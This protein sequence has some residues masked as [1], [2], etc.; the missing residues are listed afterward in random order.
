MKKFVTI[1]F[2]LVATIAQG[3]Q[4][5]TLFAYNNV[6]QIAMSADEV[7]ALSDGSLFS[8]NKHSEQLQIYNNLHS[9]GISCIYYDDT[10]A[11]LF[12]GYKTGKIDIM[13]SKGVQYI[14]DLYDKDMVQ[15]K[16]IYNVTVHGQMAYLSTHY[17]IQT[18]D[19]GTHR[20]VDS[21]WL[22]P[23]GQETT[24]SDVL[25]A[26]D[27]IYAFTTDSMFC[28]ALRDNLVDYTY[29][30][31]EGR[32][33][34]ISPDTDKGVHY[35]DGDE[36]WYAG[37]ADGIVRITPTERLVYK[38]LGPLNN[39]P[40]RITTAGNR[41]YVVSGGR[42]A[43][44]YNKPGAVMIYEDGTWTNISQADIIAEVGSPVKDF[45]NV[46]VDPF[47]NEHFF[48]TSYGTGLYEFREGTAVNK[49]L[50]A[51]DNPLESAVPSAPQTYTR[52]DYATYD[53]EGN[54]WFING[55]G[56][57]NPIICLDAQKE[58]HALPLIVDNQYAMLNCPGG[59][60]LDKS[61]PNYK[62]ISTARSNTTLFLLDDNGTPF[63]ASDDKAIG[64]NEWLSPS[65]QRITIENIL[66]MIQTKDGRI[67]L[68]TDIG[69]IIIDTTD[70]FTDDRCLRPELMD[71]NGENPMVSQRV[72]ALC[73]DTSGR[74]W[75]GTESLG[76]YVLNDQAT[77]I[78]A[79]YT[80]DNT[81]M[82]SNAI[83]S[84]AC[85]E[86]GIFYVGSGEGLIS[87]D[88]NEP[89]QGI[90]DTEE[91]TELDPGSMKQWRLHNSYYAPEELATSP[92]YVFAVASGALYAVNRQTE[93]IE[94]WSK[95]TGLTGSSIQHIAYDAN[96]E[97]L[98]ITYENGRIDLLNKN[99]D[100]VPMPDLF[101]KANSVATTV[102]GITVGKK[103]TYLAMTFGVI[104]IHPGKAEVI[105]TYYIG[106]GATSVD[107]KQVVEMGDSIYAF[108][109]DRM[110]CA[111]L[112]DNLVDYAYWQSVALPTDGLTH[113][114]AFNG[115]LYVLLHNKL[116][117]LEGG[118]W[119]QV[120][121]NELEWIHVSGGQLLA[122][123]NNNGL[124]R[125]TDDDQ[126]SGITSNYT[127][128][129]AVYSQGEYWLAQENSGLVRISSAGVNYFYPAGPSTNFAY[130]LTAAHD[131]IYMVNGGR[132]ASQ[133]MRTAAINTFNG[134]DWKRTNW[135][136]IYLSTNA[137]A[138]DPVSIAVDPNDAG[139]YFVA[140][141]TAGVFEFRDYKPIK[142]HSATNSTLRAVTNDA[143]YRYYTR[144]DGATM[145]AE[146]NLWVMNATSIGH[147]LHVLT[148]D[149]QWHAIPLY[150]G[151]QSISFTTPSGIHIDYRNS[152]RKWMIEQRG[153]S[154]VILFDDGGTPTNTS[155]DHSIKRSTWIDQNSRA[156][157]PDF[158][159]CLSQDL[160]NRIWIGTSAGI[161]IIPSNV[162][163]LNSNACRRI[164]I[165]RNDGTGLGDYLLGDER[166]N[167]MAVDGGNRMWIGTENSGL[168]LIE[169]DTI[170]V[171]HFTENNS[172]LPSNSI[173]SIAIQPIT[174]EVFVG[175][176]RGL[177]S[178]RSDASAPQND[179]SH[180]YAYPNPVR[181]NYGGFVSIAGL[182]DETVVNIV[183]AGGN[184]VCKTKSHGG[185]AV[186]D[187]R[188]AYGKRATPGVY[189]ALCNEPNGKHTIVKILVIK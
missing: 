65:G 10:S 172:L 131:Q 127:A 67:W 81:P 155:D 83:L 88:V 153:E 56:V 175:T 32:T 86:R 114:T 72:T 152:K 2:L 12:I 90:P 49:Y 133:F 74:I 99:G 95:A 123:Q 71:N 161:I 128:K 125:I 177:A 18:F 135:W 7:Y 22:R 139:H 70:Y 85:D 100:V 84:L 44:Q 113:A 66:D 57:N 52:L 120:V 112:Q 9:T 58:W 37:K 5:K 28:A 149:G 26:N 117:R 115:K 146:G 164:I 47:D 130:N 180:A 42:W 157:T 160:D 20:L 138:Y 54:L 63:D 109:D 145:D 185:L 68:G 188:N 189:T 13:S 107:V 79:H 61:H 73:Q 184:L 39:T 154:G 6:T 170:T 136:D 15:Q 11:Q 118:V 80:S 77:E 96:S 126:L 159:L 141:Y 158:V 142:Q 40:Y 178:Y 98:I 45:M 169:D 48:V 183:D 176:S 69:V 33:G 55:G 103:A 29:W 140:T 147:P 174:G 19:L 181:P 106:A 16:T 92:T 156:I 50:P 166:I 122:Y 104:A 51:E 30:K 46:A 151:S 168:Y 97:R 162:D 36:H 14:G 75:V 110:Y 21:Y 64:R 35:Q 82:P 34:R 179:L 101:M 116:L 119:K 60:L 3:Q 129:D 1:V 134:S 148:P 4:W 38:P 91:E 23:D 76:V 165:P 8:V 144:T 43:S 53:H 93:E 62:W 102:N 182:M 132:W 78:L 59:L 25:I 186:W 124:L 150:N 31:R 121:P 87:C 27:S 173:Q 17:G 89:T 143:D 137:V 24:I 167:C 105:D 94:Y 163:F 108:S 171:A 187:L 41:V 111:A